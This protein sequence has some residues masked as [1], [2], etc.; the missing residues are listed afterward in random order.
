MRKGLL[1]IITTLFFIGVKGQDLDWMIQSGAVNVPDNNIAIDAN[2][3]V[4]F[5]GGLMDTIDIDPGP[6]TV[7]INPSGIHSSDAFLAKYDSQ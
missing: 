6:D 3:N 5:V 7:L 4:Y 2:G 1:V